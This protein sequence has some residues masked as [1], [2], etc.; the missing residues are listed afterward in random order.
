[1]VDIYNGDNTL[2]EVIRNFLEN[3]LN[4]AGKPDTEQL[5]D[6]VLGKDFLQTDDDLVKFKQIDGT[7]RKVEDTFTIGMITDFL[8]I[9]EPLKGLKLIRYSLPM[10]F[11]VSTKNKY[12]IIKESLERFVELL[13]GEDYDESGYVFGTN[14]TEMTN[15][16]QVQDINGVEYVKLTCTVFITS[17]TEALLG[18]KIETHFGET[19]ESKIRIYPTDR[20]TTR[21]F[22]PEETHKNNEKESTTIFKESTWVSNLSFIVTKQSTLFEKLIEHLEEPKSLNKTWIHN[23]KYGTIGDYTKTVGLQ[24][25]TLDGEIGNYA[26]LTIVMKKSGIN[27]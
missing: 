5:V 8:G 18:N 22:I 25:L 1:M 12:D 23:V 3:L 27:L 21:A 17:T 16:E 4:Q 24:G 26:L 9:P 10:V 13:I 6:F 2:R 20:S 19:E 14:C 11:L 7:Y 15:T